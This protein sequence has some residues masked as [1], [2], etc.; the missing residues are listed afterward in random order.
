MPPRKQDQTAKERLGSPSSPE[1]LSPDPA[2]TAPASFAGGDAGQGRP[3][4]VAAEDTPLVDEALKSVAEQNRAPAS[5]VSPSEEIAALRAE[6]ARLTESAAEIAAAT[7]RVGRTEASEA[8][9]AARS[10]IRNRPVAAVA[11]AA[12]VGCLWGLR[13]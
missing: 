8:L 9:E 4:I 12:L 3:V 6:V 1:S 13:R 11:L 7:V 10:Q 2:D 5:A